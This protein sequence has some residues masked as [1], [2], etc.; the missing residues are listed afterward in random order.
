MADA[1]LPKWWEVKT[2]VDVSQ[3]G[4]SLKR[5][6]KE[7]R[8]GC[9][10]KNGWISSLQNLSVQDTEIFLSKDC[11]ALN[12]GFDDLDEEE[13]DEI[14]NEGAIA[15]MPTSLAQCQVVMDDL[16]AIDPD[17]F[18]REWIHG[19]LKASL[20]SEHSIAIISNPTDSRKSSGVFTFKRN[21]TLYEDSASLDIFVSAFHCEGSELERGVLLAAF[22]CVIRNDVETSYTSLARSGLQRK[23]DVDV[24]VE[25]DD[26]GM[27]GIYVDIAQ[28]ALVDAFNVD[29]RDIEYPEWLDMDE[30]I[31][32]STASHLMSGEP[33]RLA[34]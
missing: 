4:R 7:H 16:V 6:A 33:S 5:L 1:Q 25:D 23:F 3:A 20:L 26:D 14:P 32:C 22:Y 10:P 15:W 12:S 8:I 18:S 24:H 13:V 27:Y 9:G 21:M 30:F 2:D 34:L 19:S 28:T 29:G 11:I 17:N 31:R